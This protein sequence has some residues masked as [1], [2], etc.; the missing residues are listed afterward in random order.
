MT[1]FWK[2]IRQVA[3]AL[4]LAFS[5]TPASVNGQ[6]GT[7]QLKGV[8]ADASGG[9]IPNAAIT[10]DSATQKFTRNDNRFQRGIPYSGDPTRRFQFDGEGIRLPG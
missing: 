5:I 3:V 2:W 8:V 1:S 7:A 10:L 6:V 4:A 9:V